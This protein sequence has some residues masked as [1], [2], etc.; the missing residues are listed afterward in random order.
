MTTAGQRWAWRGLA[1]ALVVAA[2]AGAALGPYRALLVGSVTGSRADDRPAPC[3]PGRTV[4][5][6]DSPHITQAE[7]A[8]VHYN[9]EPP[10]SGPHFAFVAA[11]GVYSAPVADGLTVHALEHGHVVIQYSPDLDRQS[12]NELTRL[13]RR[14]PADVILA[15]REGL[16]GIALTAWGR[17][18]LL[19]SFDRDRIVRFVEAMRGRFVHGWTRRDSC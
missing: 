19:S 8:T 9:S 13:A 3:L 7:A 14:Y 18:D 12:A 16:A 10:T 1:I 4:P 6:M 17:I 5:L 11:P 15:P 2:L